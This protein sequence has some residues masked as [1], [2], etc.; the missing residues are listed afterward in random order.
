MARPRT[1]TKILELK[2]AY[3]KNPQ[4]ERGEEP[5]AKEGIGP[6]PRHFDPDQKKVWRE[7][8]KLCAPGVLTRQDRPAFE[9]IIIGLDQVRRGVETWSEERQEMVR[10]PAS[11]N[12]CDRVF[13]QL[14]K[15]GMTPSE[16]SN[17][18]VP[19]EK[20]DQPKFGTLG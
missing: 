6:P 8:S 15:F 18:V 7:I 13:K 4:R 2:G 16:R 20:P 19:K 17:V 1:P 12:H 3:R 14:G 9:I 10:V 5:K 11:S